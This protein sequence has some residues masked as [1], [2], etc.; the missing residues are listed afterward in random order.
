MR[1]PRNL[2]ILNI[3]S[4]CSGNTEIRWKGSVGY[5]PQGHAIFESE[6]FGARAAFRQLQQYWNQGTRSVLDIC[7]TWAPASDTIGSIGGT[8]KNSP[9]E[10]AAFLSERTGLSI[11]EMLPRL[12]DAPGVYI[13]L[14]HAMA[15]YEQGFEVR[16]SNV[17]QG[18]ALWLADFI[19]EKEL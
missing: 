16:L 5:D 7:E 10:Y 3:K 9:V 14:V 18:Y 17:V 8:E 13:G 19:E 2:N 4:A 6:A 11:H 1:K 12:E 15:R